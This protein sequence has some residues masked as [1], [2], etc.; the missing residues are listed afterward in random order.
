MAVLH[1]RDAGKGSKGDV[2][3][4]AFS[5]DGKVIATGSGNDGKVK[6]WNLVTGE[7]GP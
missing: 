5:V 4:V 2:Y 7:M 3:C 1:G 6:I